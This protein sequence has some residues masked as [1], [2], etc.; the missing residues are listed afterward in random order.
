VSQCENCLAPATWE[1]AS[2]TVM[3]TPQGPWPL[4]DEHANAGMWWW[5]CNNDPAFAGRAEMVRTIT[6]TWLGEVPS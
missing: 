2:V 1:L 5:L 3:G 6:I 4:C